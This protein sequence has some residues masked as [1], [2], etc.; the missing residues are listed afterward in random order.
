MDP[1]IHGPEGHLDCCP[2]CGSPVNLEPINGSGVPCP[3]CGRPLWFVR[4]SLDGAAVI[5][6]LTGLVSAHATAQQVDE[7]LAAAG[8]CSRLVLDL[9]RL[10]FLP[11]SFLK[12]LVLLNHR[13][14]PS[15]STR[16]CGLDELNSTSLRRTRID[17][18]FEICADQQKALE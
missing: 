10:R 9:S 5:T 14:G 13:L 15:V 17:R 1:S 2:L 16:I 8:P 4:K 11:A 7:L 18:L 12:L 6:F 3:R